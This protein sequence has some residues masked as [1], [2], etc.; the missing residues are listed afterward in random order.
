MKTEIILYNSWIIP[1]QFPYMHVCGPANL[2]C[3]MDM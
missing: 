2:T 1:S 3:N